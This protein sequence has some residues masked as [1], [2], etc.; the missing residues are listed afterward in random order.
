M[1][2]LRLKALNAGERRKREELTQKLLAKRRDVVEMEKGHEF[3][4]A[5]EDVSVAEVAEWVKAE[6]KCCP[7][8]DFHMIWR[9]KGG[10]CA[11]V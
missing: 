1:F 9:S 6:S 2:S 11:C 5:P 10:W 7:F 8:F 3:Q 4:C